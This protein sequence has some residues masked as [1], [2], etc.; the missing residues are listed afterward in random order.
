MLRES[1]GKWHFW[2]MFI[3]FWLTFMPQYKLGLEGMPRRVATYPPGLGWQFL[4]ELS[5]IGAFIIA[6]S[7]VFM[8]VNLW[9]SWRK[10]VRRRRQSRGTATPSSGSPPRPRST[11]TSRGSRR[12]A[13]SARS[14]TSTIPMPSPSRT[15]PTATAQRPR[16]GHRSVRA[17]TA[18]SE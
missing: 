14:G 1:L 8:L 4:N 16:A 13:P 15:A 5:T 11:T 18:D 10:P 12:C 9:V 2:L 6:I 7:F 17:P 3:G